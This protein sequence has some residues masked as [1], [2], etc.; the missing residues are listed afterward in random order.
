MNE[1]I[2]EACNCKVTTIAKLAIV[3]IMACN[4]VID[5]PLPEWVMTMLMFL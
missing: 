4:Q 5:K 3:H 1:N 2:S